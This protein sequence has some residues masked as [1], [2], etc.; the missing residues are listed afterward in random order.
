MQLVH[1]FPR[2][3][4][5]G[6]SL[7]VCTGLISLGL[8]GSGVKATAK[9]EFQQGRLQH[10]GPPPSKPGRS[11]LVLPNLEE[12]RQRPEDKLKIAPPIESRMRSRRKPLESRRG[13]KV[14]DPLPR[15]KK[16]DSGIPN[17][18]RNVAQTFGE[19]LQ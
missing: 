12:I 1:P 4:V 11:H 8:I 13:L 7:Y 5:R 14:G 15:K 3:M 6:I 2:W 16:A 18:N 19:T 10:K 17:T 9:I